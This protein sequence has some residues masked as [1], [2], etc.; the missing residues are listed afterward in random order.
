MEL[1][2]LVCLHACVLA[3]L[4]VSAARLLS[5][6]TP[7]Y[8]IRCQTWNL[9]TFVPF[10]LLS[11]AEAAK[12]TAAPK[13]KKVMQSVFFTLENGNT[14]N[15]FPRLIEH[16]RQLGMPD[17][18]TKHIS[19]NSGWMWAELIAA[20]LL[21]KLQQILAAALF[22]GLS[23]DSSEA[24]GHVDYESIVVYYCNSLFQREAVFAFLLEVGL[25]TKQ[26][27]RHSWCW[28][29]SPS[30]R[31]VAESMLCIQVSG[32]AS[33]YEPASF[34]TRCCLRLQAFDV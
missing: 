18:S 9:I 4:L 23:M 28:M 33:S 8:I 13:K 16:M 30:W 24:V 19:Y 6:V 29:P 10:T 17:V 21:G 27:V 34:A 32:F 15:D 20:V 5:F 22:F 3:G 12:I 7:R 26:L 31:L 14:M 11:L 2:C 25:N 1:S